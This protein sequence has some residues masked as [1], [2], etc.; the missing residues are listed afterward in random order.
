M[1]ALNTDAIA[2]TNHVASTQASKNNLDPRG[3]TIDTI[4]IAFAFDS[5]YAASGT[6]VLRNI[7]ESDISGPC[8]FT[9]SIAVSALR[10]SKGQAKDRT[11]H[12]S[13]P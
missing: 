4:S 13:S 6:V 9:S 12:T 3:T 5:G 11:I 1:S 2:D 10:T 7:T 8:P